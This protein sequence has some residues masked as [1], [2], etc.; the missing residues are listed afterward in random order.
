MC[1]DGAHDAPESPVTLTPESSVT[2]AGIR[3]QQFAEAGFIEVPSNQIQPGDCALMTIHSRGVICHAAVLHDHNTIF[4]HT[5]SR[6]GTALSRFESHGRW[7]KFIAKY[8]R[9]SPAVNTPAQE[10]KNNNE[11]ADHPPTRR[12]R[13]KVHKRTD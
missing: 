1:G 5:F 11:A 8:V 2:F 7:D 13:R 9:Y 6:S 3:K 4:H 12:S 10:N